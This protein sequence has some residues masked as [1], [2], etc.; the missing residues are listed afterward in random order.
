MK[1]LRHRKINGE[2]GKRCVTVVILSLAEGDL[3]GVGVLR[4][5]GAVLAGSQADGAVM[6][7]A[8]SGLSAPGG[9][10]GS[11]WEAE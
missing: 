5:T 7:M 8:R 11:T 1:K 3:Q 6:F 2:A 10:E 4:M 9:A